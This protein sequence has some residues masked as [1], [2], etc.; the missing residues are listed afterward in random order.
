MSRLKDYWAAFTWAAL[1]LI[2]CLIP[3][4]EL[5]DINFW[6][7]NIEDKLAHIGVFGILSFL[8]VYGAHGRKLHQK[9]WYYFWLFIMSGLFYGAMTEILQGLF[10][11][12]RY[13]SFGDFI[14]DG[15]GTILGTIVA[16]W[17]FRNKGESKS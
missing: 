3:G 10:V 15:I 12:T 14:A 1:I 2:L 8:L 5:P 7:L 13:A 4:D 16:F 6:E 11:P 17:Y 9:T